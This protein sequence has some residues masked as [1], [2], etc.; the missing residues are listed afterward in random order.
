VPNE[1]II[2]GVYYMPCEYGEWKR[3]YHIDPEDD[4][5]IYGDNNPPV[6][7]PK[8]LVVE[9]K[10]CPGKPTLYRSILIHSGRKYGEWQY[11]PRFGEIAD[12]TK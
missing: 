12:G 4:G 2:D 9:R 1:V 8:G 5:F 3:A 10:S 11:S 6:R 7:A